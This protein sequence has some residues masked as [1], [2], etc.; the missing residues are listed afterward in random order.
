MATIYL[1]FRYL[2]DIDYPPGDD[3]LIPYRDHVYRWLRAYERA[4][5]RGNPPPSAAPTSG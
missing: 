4:T 5:P 3:R 1:T 2:A